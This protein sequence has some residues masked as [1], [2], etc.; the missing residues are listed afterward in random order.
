MTYGVASTVE[1]PTPISVKG[2][3][4]KLKKVNIEKDVLESTKKALLY[5]ATL[6]SATD[7]TLKNI[8]LT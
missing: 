7:I 6:T 8:N 2:Y 1:T 3:D 5:E 4:I